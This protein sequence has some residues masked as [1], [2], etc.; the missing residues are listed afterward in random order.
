MSR[1]TDPELLEAWS[2]HHNGANEEAIERFNRILANRPGN[3]DALNGL[4]LSQKALGDH[5]GARVT[6]KKMIQALE[7]LIEEDP[8]K[9]LRATM[10]IRMA[11]QQIEMLD[12]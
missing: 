9:S 7:K 5:L 1:E 10:E 6:F 12:T 8:D 3:H 2:L 4:A 11:K